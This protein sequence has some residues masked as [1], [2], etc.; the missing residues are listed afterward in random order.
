MKCCDT[1]AISGANG[2]I[3]S[4]GW[5]EINRV[6]SAHMLQTL[7]TLF[8]VIAALIVFFHQILHERK[9]SNYVIQRCQREMKQKYVMFKKSS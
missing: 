7:K 1:C 9:Y 6:S 2:F 3:H 4:S 8:L 5:C